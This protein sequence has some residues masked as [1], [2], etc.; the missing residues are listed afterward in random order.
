M[1]LLVKRGVCIFNGIGPNI[2]NLAEI[3]KW[4]KPR[5]TVSLRSSQMVIIY[6]FR[7]TNIFQR[8]FNN[9]FC[10][11]SKNAYN[12]R[13]SGIYSTHRRS[14]IILKLYKLTPILNASKS[15]YSTY[16]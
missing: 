8:W 2:P 1:G 14:L 12:I 15:I 16:I 3:L 7:I 10:N 4:N 5:L 11:K 13:I 9:A 6:N